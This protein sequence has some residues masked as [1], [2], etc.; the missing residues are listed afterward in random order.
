MN[1][2]RKMIVNRKENCGFIQIP[3]KLQIIIIIVVIIVVVLLITF[4]L[5]K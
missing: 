4:S 5:K 2:K 3:I 1:N